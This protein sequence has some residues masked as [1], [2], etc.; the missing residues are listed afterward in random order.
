MIFTKNDFKIK[1]TVVYHHTV[2]LSYILVLQPLMLD[3]N[4][5]NENKDK[6]IPPISSDN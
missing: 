2:A 6:N 3:F 4:L 1:N 5:L